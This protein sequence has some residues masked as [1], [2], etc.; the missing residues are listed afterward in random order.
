MTL[1][2]PDSFLWGT[3]SNF[4]KIE[5]ASAHNFQGLRAEDGHILERT[6]NHEKQRLADV[7]HIQRFGTSYRCSIDWAR[8][9]AKPYAAFANGVVQAYRDF[10]EALNN[11]GIKITLVLHHTCHPSW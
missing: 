8:L 5:T 1:P 9:Q 2:F 10:F 11:R 6:T 7:D 4:G 3:A